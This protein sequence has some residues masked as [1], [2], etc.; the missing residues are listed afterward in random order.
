MPET[1]SLLDETPGTERPFPRSLLYVVELWSVDGTRVERCLAAAAT[2]SIGRM[3]FDAAVVTFPGR[4]LT[5][6]GPGVQEEWRAS[7]LRLSL[8]RT[9]RGWTNDPKR[10]ALPRAAP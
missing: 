1:E 4:T 9:R 2:I 10:L 8:R 3:A 5:L 6:K 7:A